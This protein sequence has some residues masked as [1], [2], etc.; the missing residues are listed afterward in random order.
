MKKK[1]KWII[2]SGV[3]LLVLLVVF[4]IV[5]KITSGK[6]DLAELPIAVRVMS[7]VVGPVEDALELSGSISGKEE[8][9]AYSKVPGRLARYERTEGEWVNKDEVIAWIERD[10]VG[11]Q[12]SLSPVKSPIN[13]QVAQHLVD[14]G[15]AV[16]GGM[17]MPGTPVA[18]VVDPRQLEINVHVIEREIGK[19]AVGQKVKVNV[20]SFPEETFLGSVTRVAPVLDPLSRTALVK[21]TLQK[22]GGKLKSGMLADVHII[23]AQKEKG[24]LIPRDAVLKQNRLRFV[25][26]VQGGK[27]HRQDV[28]TGWVQGDRLEILAGVSPQ[29]Q[30]VVQ[31]QSRLTESSSVKIVE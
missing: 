21:I 4:R 9:N 16:S 11:L 10:E 5:G 12:Y 25:Y 13:G 8:A 30:V 31:G 1:T 19:V 23:V 24:L 28:Q 3:G 17:G 15:E 20:T 29:D 2:W 14:I 6:A 27:V 7:P 18:R 22:S 26:V